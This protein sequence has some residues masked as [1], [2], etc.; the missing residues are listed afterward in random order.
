MYVVRTECTEYVILDFVLRLHIL[1]VC[2]QL[3]IHV[4]I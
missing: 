4:D 2:V 3:K 1:P